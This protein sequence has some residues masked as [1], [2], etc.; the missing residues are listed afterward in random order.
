MTTPV[1]DWAAAAKTAA[2][3]ADAWRGE[4]GPG[5]AIVLFD[6]DGV[7]GEFCGGAE[8]LATMVPFRA[9]SVVRFASITKHI[10]CAVVL[11]HADKI[12]LDDRLGDHLPQLKGAL[13]DVT[14][15]R[16]LD[17]TGG[18][19]DVRETLST[20]GIS[21]YE[22]VKAQPILDFLG[23]IEALNFPA[24]SQISYSN[25]GYRLVEAALA[26]KGVVFAQ[27][28]E[29]LIAGPLGIAMHAPEF[30]YDTVPGLAPGY[31][32]SPEGWQ[33]GT[34]GLHFSSSGSISSS[35]RDMS[36][37]LRSILTDEG[38]GKGMFAA[39]S[40]PRAL[41][42]GR[43]T[44]YGLGFVSTA[45]GGETFYGHGGSQS[46]YKS[47]F[48]MDPRRGAG[49]VIAS[50]RE[51][52]PAAEIALK[53]M[54]SLAGA[55]LPKRSTR[56]PDGLYA[57]ADGGPFWLEV[58]GPVAAFLGTGETLYEGED[59]WSVSLS[60][61]MPVRLRWTGEEIEGEVGHAPRR[62]SPV[63]APEKT[64]AIEG[65]WVCPEHHAEFTIED[66]RFV[67][68]AGPVRRA[69]A[70]TSLGGGRFV[71]E[72]QD[73]PWP[74]RICL[75]FKGDEVGLHLNRSRVIRYRRG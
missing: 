41:V 16:A 9:D 6:R 47:N 30:W 61:H 38:P 64:E 4:D 44:R 11:R 36:V 14:V 7:R 31:W 40:A 35:A 53:V 68:G 8:S 22:L 43:E 62:F 52:T 46:G 69:E 51:E 56:L 10:F 15:G 75:A 5:G 21:L 73:G 58:K 57:S 67:S 20:L 45:L 72:G 27:E 29:R 63:T 60:A 65:R 17:M 34:S 74:K 1:S 3:I 39:L 33:L 19:P 50:N 55:A 71:V 32:R 49:V 59:G 54:A 12:G 42:D 48:L 2:A 24:G 28:I 66:G 13:A 70:L 37:W 23:E 26:A 25:T 18:L